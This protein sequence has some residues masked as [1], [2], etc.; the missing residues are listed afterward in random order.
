M[1]TSQI[2]IELSVE[3]EARRRPLGEKLTARTK[4][5]SPPRLPRGRAVAVSH[6]QTLGLDPPVAKERLNG[7]RVLPFAGQEVPSCVSEHVRVDR[8]GKSSR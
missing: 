5:R 7:S 6:S 4:P 3:A 8:E 2:E 1:V